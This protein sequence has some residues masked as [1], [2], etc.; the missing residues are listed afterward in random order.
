MM[1]KTLRSYC[2]CCVDFHEE[3]YDKDKYAAEI[4][5]I[6]NLN[7]INKNDN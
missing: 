2:F 5:D 7:Y 1:S 4:I 6:T 3:I